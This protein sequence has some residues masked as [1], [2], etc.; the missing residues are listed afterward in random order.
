ML[1]S[2]TN[3]NLERNIKEEKCVNEHIKYEVKKL[4]WGNHFE[5]EKFVKKHKI[6][7]YYY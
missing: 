3:D 5:F 2:L 7:Y 1:I 6:D 4:L